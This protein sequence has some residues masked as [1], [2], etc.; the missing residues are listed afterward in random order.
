MTPGPG[1]GRASRRG[2]GLRLGGAV[3]RLAG[4]ALGLVIVFVL[5][6]A[7]AV[8]LHLDI[9]PLRRVAAARVQSILASGIQGKL[10]I[11][12][13]GKLDFG[14]I[15]EGNAYVLDPAGK[16][17]AAA[18]GV[19]ARIALGELVRT[20]LA[21][22]GPLDVH[23]SEVSARAADFDL[24]L[25]ASGQL[26][27]VR[28]F[29]SRTPSTGGG[30]RGVRLAI[31]RIA[32]GHAWVHGAPV[33]GLTVD[34]D[35]DSLRNASVAIDP[36]HVA[37]DVGAFALATRGMPFGANAR[38][39]AE[40]HLALP[41]PS[42]GGVGLRI[43][44]DGAV[45]GIPLSAKGSLD[46]EAIDAVIDAP[47]VSPA[48]VRALWP[49]SPIDGPATGHVDVHGA[50]PKLDVH[51]RSTQ[52]D[53][54]LDLTGPVV[55]GPGQ[56]AELHV[57]ARAV[58]VH[59]IVSSAPGSNLSLSGDVSLTRSA[60]G[61]LGAK[62]AVD[63][64]G[65][66]VAGASIPRGKI[67][68][69]LSQDASRGVRADAT[70]AANEPGA[71]TVLRLHLL[72][73]GRSYELSFDGDTRVASLAALPR[74]GPIARGESELTTHGAIDFGRGE[75]DLKLAAEIRGLG[76]DVL[77][78]QHAS[79]DAR[80]KGS[81]AAPQI[82]VTVRGDVLDFG[83][84]RFSRAQIDV[85]GPARG[86]DVRLSL[87][88]DGD[89]TPELAADGQL[90]VGSVTKV[91]QI[92]VQVARLREAVS[93]R[94]GEI[95]VAH[96]EIAVDPIDV[97][98]LGGPLH[99]S[100]HST[101]GAAHVE[102]KGT[103]VDLARFERV[104]RVE[105][106]LGCI[107]AI[108]VDATLRRGGADGHASIEVSR[109]TVQ[110]MEGASAGVAATFEGRKI[111]GRAH[112]ELEDAGSFEVVAPAIE[113]GGKGTLR[114]SWRKAIGKV[115]FAGKIDLAKLAARLPRHAVPLDHVRGV[116]TVQG[117]AQRDSTTDDTPDF[118]VSLSTSGLV[119]IGPSARMT[120]VDGS[121]V[122]TPPAW[123]L[124]GIDL[125]LDAR[126]D[127]DSG[128]AA[129]AARLNDAKGELI[130]IDL[131]S[132]AVPYTAMIDNPAQAL[133][134][135]EKVRFN[136]HV[137]VPPRNVRDLPPVLALAGARGE[138]S[139]DV[140]ATGTMLEPVVALKASILKAR[141]TGA[142][143]F[144]LDLD[145][146][147]HYDGV[148]ADASLVGAAKG[149][150]VLDVHV[151]TMA[152]APDLLAGDTSSWTASGRAHLEAL[153][154]ESIAALS[155]RQVTGT[156]TGDVTLDGLH[157]DG[158][159]KLA[160]S[161]AT[162]KVGEVAYRSGVLGATLDG[163]SFDASMHLDQVDGSIDATAQ[164]GSK[165]GKALLPA[166]DPSRP[167]SGE[168]KAKRFRAALLLPFVDNVFTELDG[169]V[170]AD[171]KITVDPRTGRAQPQGTIAL[172][173]GRF[174]VGSIGG[175]FHDVTAKAI[176]TPDGVL[177]LEGIRASAM[178][179]AVEAAATARLD[180]LAL[181]ALNATVQIPSSNPLLLT[182]QGSQVG[183][184]EGK[185]N[186][187]LT[188]RQ[189]TV[190][191][192]VD[193]PTLH[194]ELPLTSSHDVQPLGPIEGVRI[195]LEKS[196]GFVPE[197]LDAPRQAVAAPPGKTI[198]TTVKLGEDVVVKKSTQLKV[199][200]SGSPVI[201]IGNDVRATGQVR[202]LTGKI[203]VQ[204]KSFDIESGAVTFQGDPSDPQMVVTAS[205]T[206][207]DGTQV[208]ADLRGTLKNPKVTLR[209]E[210]SFT[211]NE[212]I[213]L[214]A[215]GSADAAS[216]N[217]GAAAGVAGGAAT[218]PLNRAL[219]NMGLGGV[220]TR[221]DTSAVTPRADVEL[222]IAR[223]LSLQVA[224]VMGVPPP[225]TSP[226]TTFLTLNWRFA[227]AWS[228]QTTI[229]SLG[230]TIWD[231]IWQH[232]Y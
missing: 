101:F 130:A 90:S 102:V 110:K 39:T 227:K 212:I 143:G 12:S 83:G 19:R 149:A 68:A 176:F 32:I 92:H 141:A 213:A 30:G 179:G 116:V 118:N 85:H 228:S 167:P 100:F 196:G 44:W 87:D 26:G 142:I 132:G 139:A 121:P 78:A 6:I 198:V 172:S 89:G 188:Q 31:D 70:V 106:G 81:L 127:G 25:D 36:S 190:D 231:L 226:D 8:V 114:E 136:S 181:Q 113:I 63:F 99:A 128:F 199:A 125:G 41:A 150:Q 50:L 206:A 24:E 52:G 67:H 195:G 34:A 189:S 203:D 98:G 48:A 153:P 187:G 9:P 104:S 65:G 3:L 84:Y 175:E 27:V 119:L 219:E 215:Y 144:P 214:L 180:G 88:A 178:S 105:G 217:S 221:V 158:R 204:G 225:G 183:T 197:R 45:A 42:G 11:E 29:A 216:P 131:K 123:R 220:T 209:S 22:K 202:L 134:L 109:C 152:R 4:A 111:A 91:E 49:A 163:K 148:N 66:T 53:A 60:A 182:V 151:A 211:Q 69:T 38:G 156:V 61:A 155:D 94:V 59:T 107:A 171:V 154:L 47:E 169:R 1:A 28:A 77:T 112:V 62:A 86:A 168:L 218:Q 186:V 224:E 201:T 205:W 93:V 56:S 35:V 138:L 80:L 170:D 46:G 230:T 54:S 57:E 200:L 108:D 184:V 137:V 174:E 14:G 145:L 43:L 191:V 17:V 173:Q 82:D 73:K 79:V 229:G 129:V 185:V 193:I 232:R 33:K 103:G 115:K 194:V 71:P 192:K 135:A 97:E 21:G 126:I 160:L 161:V 51:V 96:G 147:A 140:T 20:L 207:A 40:A 5:A 18:Y 37:V 210:P 159:A 222:Q 16:V 208:Y 15:E 157:E 75:L 13:V 146:S 122:I 133:R 7:L 165:W 117:R 120:G 223:D 72:P 23:L 64:K 177:R 166:L 74:F 124:D 10:V 162:L 2:R 95:K 58:D 55:L 164:A 76:H